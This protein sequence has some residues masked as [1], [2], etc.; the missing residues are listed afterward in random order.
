MK[1]EIELIA[2]NILMGQSEVF[3]T[4]TGIIINENE[5]ILIDPGVLP[6]DLD[7]IEKTINTGNY[8]INSIIITHSHWDHLLGVERFPGVNVIT[9]E[10]YLT[11]TK[12]KFK[13]FI[14]DQISEWEKK[15]GIVR[16]NVFQLPKPDI[17]FKDNLTL[18]LGNLNLKLIY[19][20]GHSEDQLV[21]YIPERNFLWAGDMLS[22]IEI[23]YIMNSLYLYKNTLERIDSL[24]IEKLIPGHGNPAVTGEEIKNRII[25]DME[26]LKKLEDNI[27]ECLSKDNSIEETIDSCEVINFKNHDENKFCH[28]LNVESAYIEMGGNVDTAKYG[29]MKLPF[30]I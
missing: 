13:R 26:Y 16:N 15:H 28:V 2:D 12:G 29:W 27:K 6:G 21:I 22:D 19:S 9:H 1:R 4:N 8:T 14:I 20:P 17:T 24:K 18:M 7:K 23:P 25:I 3:S 30:E 5:C 11:A 10:N